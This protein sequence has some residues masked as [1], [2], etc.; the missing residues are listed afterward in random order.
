[1]SA[2]ESLPLSPRPSCGSPG[3][4][5]DACENMD[6]EMS[7]SLIVM[8]AYSTK[9]SLS[10]SSQTDKMSS[11]R[12]AKDRLDRL[13]SGHPQAN[14]GGF[15][16]DPTTGLNN[17]SSGSWRRNT[18]SSTTCPMPNFSQ[19]DPRDVSM[20]R[21]PHLSGQHSYSQMTGEE[22]VP[23]SSV[24]PGP[25]WPSENQL[26]VAYAYGIRRDDGTYT[27]LIRADEL[28]QHDFRKVPISQGPEGLITL[29]SPR[30][31]RP[32]RRVGSL[33]MISHEASI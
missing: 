1:M 22:S 26:N 3:P 11:F 16:S 4:D 28:N 7:S 19:P 32:E 24:A 23:V 6:T 5:Q 33:S 12:P 2:N 9:S 10:L 20:I 13:N 30:L 15:T 27:R 21:Q 29:P 8:D 31:M 17:A 25:V 18:T 14:N